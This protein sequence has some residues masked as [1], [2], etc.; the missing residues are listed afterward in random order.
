VNFWYVQAING[1]SYGMLLFLL[2]A[3]FSLVFGLM[4]ITNLAHGSYYMLGAYLGVTVTRFVDSFIL[5]VVVAGIVVAVLGVLMQRFVLNRLYQNP[6][7]EVLLTFGFVFII[8]DISL[9]AWGGSPLNIPPPPAFRGATTI[10][11][12]IFPTYRLLVIGVG[13]LIA[14]FLWW[15]QEGTKIGAEMRAAVDDEEISQTV[16]INVPWI[17]TVVFGVSAALAAIGGVMG[18]PFI[19]AYPGLDLEVLLMALVVTIIG[20]VGSLLGAFVGAMLVGLLD[21]FGKA[22][23]PE[24]SLFTVFAPMA[25]ILAIKPSGLFGRGS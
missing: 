11:G 13:L 2:A 12:I 22:L 9:V 25:I 8:A 21:N 19:G 14:L 20:G 5:A 7:G 15:F 6:L 3:G 17:S 1:I 10:G 4:N 18:G 23:F 16:G 24:L